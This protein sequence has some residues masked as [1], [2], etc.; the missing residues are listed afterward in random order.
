MRTKKQ[1]IEGLQKMKRN[2][3]YNGSLIDRDDE[4]QMP[5]LEVMG[6]TFDAAADPERVH[7]AVPERPESTVAEESRPSASTRLGWL[8]G[9][10]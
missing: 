1:Y 3:Y 4:L 7:P 2:L 10:L 6:V 9:L 8:A 5:T